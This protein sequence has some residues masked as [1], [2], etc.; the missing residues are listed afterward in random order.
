MIVSYL[1]IFFALRAASIAVRNELFTVLGLVPGLVLFFHSVIA[2]RKVFVQISSFSIRTSECFCCKHEHVHP[3]TG[4]PMVCDRKMV[5]KTLHNWFSPQCGSRHS[6]SAS[7]KGPD[8][9]DAFDDCVRSGLR[10]MLKSNGVDMTSL[11]TYTDAL[12]A[13]CPVLWNALDHFAEMLSHLDEHAVLFILY[14]VEEY[15]NLFFFVVPCTLRSML[16]LIVFSHRHRPKLRKYLSA[17]VVDLLT[18]L[19]SVV[20]GTT[21]AGSMWLS[22]PQLVWRH[23]SEP[24]PAETSLRSVR[25][26]LHACFTLLVF[27]DVRRWSSGIRHRKL[28]TE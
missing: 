14:Q 3:Q 19:C 9:L 27:S 5:Y 10:G 17:L 24:S 25:F 26:V 20:L 1:S 21:V 13:S 6:V 15:S 18:S 4:M 11:I 8:F 2:T 28:D 16:L 23:K 7:G 12:I 22:G